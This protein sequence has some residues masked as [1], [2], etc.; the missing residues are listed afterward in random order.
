MEEHPTTDTRRPVISIRDVV[1]MFRDQQG[2]LFRV[3]DGI[4]FDV[5]AGETLVVMGGSGCGK[6]TVAQ[7]ALGLLPGNGSVSA[8]SVRFR[9]LD[10]TGTVFRKTISRGTR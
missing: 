2:R 1:K 6:S 4:T 9:R 10:P 3:L 8:G 5:Y 7:A